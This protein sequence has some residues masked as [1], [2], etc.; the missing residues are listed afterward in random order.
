PPA[1]QAAIRK[2]A[3]ELRANIEEL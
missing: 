2:K 1:E 3:A